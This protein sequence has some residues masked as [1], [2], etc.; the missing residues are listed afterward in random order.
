M[1]LSISGIRNERIYYVSCTIS[2]KDRMCQSHQIKIHLAGVVNNGIF[3]V[4]QVSVVII[5]F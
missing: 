4:M 1:V 3:L 5:C 2:A